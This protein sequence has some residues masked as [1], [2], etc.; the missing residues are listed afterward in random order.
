MIINDKNDFENKL[1]KFKKTSFFKILKFLHF[2]FAI[3]SSLIFIFIGYLKNIPILTRIPFYYIFII[4]IHWI[5]FKNECVIQYFLKK[6]MYKNYKLGDNANLGPDT[7]ISKIRKYESNYAIYYLNQLLIIFLFVKNKTLFEYQL[8]IISIY[9][10]ICCT[11]TS[12]YI[13][14][15][16]D[17]FGHPKSKM[18]RPF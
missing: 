12:N 14:M 8:L 18:T 10:L 5:F 15:H 3:I 1:R 9:I 16:F 17:Q 6:K 2:K 4:F 11:Y 13:N 7:Y